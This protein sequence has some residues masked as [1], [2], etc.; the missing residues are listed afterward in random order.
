[1][2]RALDLQE[3]E[4]GGGLEEVWERLN[5]RRKT[6]TSVTDV[7]RRI[8]WDR[9]HGKR[10]CC[11]R[12]MVPIPCGHWQLEVE[13]STRRDMIVSLALSLPY[14]QALSASFRE[15]M[16]SVVD[17]HIFRSAPSR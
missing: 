6:Y 4:A 8:Q 12:S 15:A 13:R 10:Y 1:M 9:W 5:R 17:N 14:T 16:C 11:Q 7:P 2:K 3:G